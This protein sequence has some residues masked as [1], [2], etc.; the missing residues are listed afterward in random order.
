MAHENRHGDPSDPKQWPGTDTRH[1]EDQKASE[2]ARDLAEA[3]HT[4]E[5][6]KDADI[7]PRSRQPDARDVS[8]PRQSMDL[9][10]VRDT[11]PLE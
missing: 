9:T 10:R 4:N 7:L 3:P 11:E 6:R 2:D 1:P 8:V 5:P